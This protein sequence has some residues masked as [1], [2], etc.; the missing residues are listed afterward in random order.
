MAAAFAAF[1]G[2]ADIDRANRAKPSAQGSYRRNAPIKD[3]HRAQAQT[4]IDEAR[5]LR[6]GER[7]GIAVAAAISDKQSFN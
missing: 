6:R 1:G 4:A 3:Q 7:E 5:P 2:K